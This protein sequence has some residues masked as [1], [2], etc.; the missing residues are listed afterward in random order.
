MF[1]V[2]L[3][4]LMLVIM[5]GAFEMLIN[6]SSV[7]INRGRRE[8][9]IFSLHRRENY[10]SKICATE[11]EMLNYKGAVRQAERISVR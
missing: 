4:Q 3:E 7:Y 9:L 5:L 10:I 11:K 1:Y 8:N 2:V 6:S